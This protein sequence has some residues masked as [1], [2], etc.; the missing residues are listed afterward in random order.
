MQNNANSRDRF[1]ANLGIF[2]QPVPYGN[3]TF[4]VRLT[5]PPQVN[6][7]AASLQLEPGD[8]IISLDNMSFQVE[9]DVLGHFDQTSMVFI[10]VRTGQPQAANLMLPPQQ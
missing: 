3:G 6:S 1:A 9:N 4:G 2:Y 7:P 5:R 8:T 10:N